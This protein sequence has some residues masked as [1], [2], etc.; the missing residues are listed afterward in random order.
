MEP[1]YIQDIINYMIK[2]HI[3]E[4][5]FLPCTNRKIFENNPN[6]EKELAY[7]MIKAKERCSYT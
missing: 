5:H 6:L 4:V 2:E 7:E 1:R 3:P